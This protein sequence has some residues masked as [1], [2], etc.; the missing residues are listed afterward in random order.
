MSPHIK[1]LRL[2]QFRGQFVGLQGSDTRL[3]A[4]S[5]TAISSFCDWRSVRW[6]QK[7]S[8][9][10][11]SAFESIVESFHPKRQGLDPQNCRLTRNMFHK[12]AGFNSVPRRTVVPVYGKI[13]AQRGHWPRSLLNKGFSNVPVLPPNLLAKTVL[14]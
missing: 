9:T 11:S 10:R 14:T 13:W 7:S 1:E 12:L 8:A 5:S 3:L 6:Q 4:S 2:H